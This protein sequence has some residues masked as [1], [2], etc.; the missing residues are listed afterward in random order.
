[1][2]IILVFLNSFRI[3]LNLII[4]IKRASLYRRKNGYARNLS[5]EVRLVINIDVYKWKRLTR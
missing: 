2:N 1:M 5:M 4:S 3:S